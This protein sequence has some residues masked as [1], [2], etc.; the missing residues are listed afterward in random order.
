[1]R[2]DFGSHGVRVAGS[3][4]NQIRAVMLKVGA[5]VANGDAVA[6]A[7]PDRMVVSATIW[8]GRT[9]V[10]EAPRLCRSPRYGNLAPRASV[11]GRAGS[12]T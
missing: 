8:V 3:R 12:K 2:D 6:R 9:S 10:V 5:A 4:A 1:M 7:A 11:Y